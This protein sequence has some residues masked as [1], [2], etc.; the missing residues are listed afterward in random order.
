M[1]KIQHLIYCHCIAETACSEKWSL[2][3]TITFILFTI[4]II[5]FIIVSNVTIISTTISEASLMGF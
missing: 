1:H 3:F 5:N 2:V 4:I